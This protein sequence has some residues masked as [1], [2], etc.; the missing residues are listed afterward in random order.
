VRAPILLLA[1]AAAAAPA[2]VATATSSSAS[3][4]QSSV[5]CT[6]LRHAAVSGMVRRDWLVGDV[7]GDGVADRVAVVEDTHAPFR[8]RYAI[9]VFSGHRVLLRPLGRFVDKPEIGQRRPLIR[10]L[11]RIDRRRGL[12][13]VVAVSAGA[14][15]EQAEL[16]TV[17][18]GRLQR[19]TFTRYG[20][21][22]SYGSIVPAGNSFDCAR[23]ASG[24]I[25][26]AQFGALDNNGKRWWYELVD[27]RIHGLEIRKVR[28]RLA[29]RS[30]TATP[31][32][33]WW[34]TY[35]NELRPF[36]RCVAVEH[37]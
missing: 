34:S 19:F 2:V 4:D 1:A 36:R 11:A 6:N 20:V 23:P 8:C 21:I 15:S 28:M 3:E 14:S 37:S 10:S 33:R 31:P 24:K 35:Y 32:P 26:E 16:L 30:G 29:R 27:Y 12:E 9:A 25:V 5:H 7:T 13:I 18:H 22:F 17:R